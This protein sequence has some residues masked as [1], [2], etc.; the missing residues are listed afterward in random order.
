MSG[1][2]LLLVGAIYVAVG[3]GY[4][5]AG[6]YGMAL[7]FAAYAMANAGFACDVWMNQ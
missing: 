2:L 7:A 6:R 5:R 3:I 1:W 4:Y